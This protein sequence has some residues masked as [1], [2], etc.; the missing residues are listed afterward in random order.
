[1]Y[2]ELRRSKTDQAAA[3]HALPYPELDESLAEICPVRALKD[4]LDALASNYAVTQGHIFRR[5]TRWGKLIEPDTPLSD[6][7]VN[8]LV[9]KL[10]VRM[11]IP[12]R[13][14]SAHVALRA[15]MATQL[16]RDGV[17]MSVIKAAGRW[18]SDAVASG[19]IRRSDRDLLGALRGV[20]S[21]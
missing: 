1:M 16:D 8:L 3:G 19:Y 11:G 13:Q 15:G 9:K 4:W 5:I 2:I 14:I 18:K 7:V 17:P 21:S 20:R 12:A 6:Q 10:A